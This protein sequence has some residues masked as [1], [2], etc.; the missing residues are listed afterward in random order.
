V[1]F[2]GLGTGLMGLLMS[3]VVA[4][5]L[6]G[7]MIGRTPE[8]LGKTFG[9]REVK[10]A[11]GYALVLPA[12]IL[13]L[14][15]LALVLPAGQ[16]GLSGNPVPRRLTE[17]VFAYASCVT[18][19]GQSMGALAVDSPFWNLTTALAMLLGRF[20]TAALALAL[21]GSVSVQRR[22]PVGEG[23]LPAGS[24]LFGGLL[25]A[26]VLL[27]GGLC[28]LPVLVLGPIAEQVSVRPPGSIP[29]P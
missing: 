18:N 11:I 4:V 24:P 17:V 7:L 25:L 14:S 2:G 29:A 9:S 19:N 3:A 22:R 28:F 20:G 16:A 13:A 23:S 15:A 1:A 12:T 10:L 21:A 8:Y 5:F 27:I 26:T 6:A